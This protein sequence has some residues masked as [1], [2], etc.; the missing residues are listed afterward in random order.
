[1]AGSDAGWTS[2]KMLELGTR[3]ATLE[4]EGDLDGTMATLIEHPIY[5]FWPI[6][7]RMVGRERVRRYYEHLIDEFMPRQI[8]F[9]M[10][11]ETISP[12]ALSQE[13]IIEMKGSGGPEFHRVLGILIGAP[14]S[15]G[16]MSGE[17][18][19]GSEDFLR[20]MIGPIWDELEVISDVEPD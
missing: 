5:E 15:P 12:G 11:E 10:I 2:E 13:Y 4:T 19:W 17:R 9:T 3:H 7:K 16:L 18:I 8:G 20:Q 14:D 6:G 1:M